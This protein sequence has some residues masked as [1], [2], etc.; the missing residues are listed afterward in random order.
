MDRRR[1]R[2]FCLGATAPELLEMKIPNPFFD[3]QFPPL[4]GR[5]Y[6]L[7]QAAR[8]DTQFLCH[9][10][11]LLVK[12]ATFLCLFP[13]IILLMP[14]SHRSVIRYVWPVPAAI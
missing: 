9:S 3:W 5:R 6:I 2:R 8:A 10:D 14:R 1:S 12:P 7:D 4:L 13:F 11:V